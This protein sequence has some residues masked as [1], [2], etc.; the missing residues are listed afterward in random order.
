MGWRVVPVPYW[1]SSSIL[2]QNPPGSQTLRLDE[3]VN[4]L[5]DD[6][7]FTAK[8]SFEVR[9]L[10]SGRVLRGLVESHPVLPPGTQGPSGSVAVSYNFRHGSG[11]ENW[12]APCG[13]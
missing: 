9:R 12:T 6:D 4:S 11:K 2:D 8:L 1:T 10:K 13:D 3:T 7:P 5:G